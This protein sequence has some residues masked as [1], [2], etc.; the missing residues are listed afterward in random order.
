MLRPRRKAASRALKRAVIPDDS[1]TEEE[2]EEEGVQVRSRGTH[3]EEEEETE[4]EEE[5]ESETEEKELGQHEDY[6]L[7]DLLAVKVQ[8]LIHVFLIMHSPHVTCNRKPSHTGA[9][10]L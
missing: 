1:E 3:D 9:H 10:F 7:A 4:E 5:D 2:E 6:R 8:P